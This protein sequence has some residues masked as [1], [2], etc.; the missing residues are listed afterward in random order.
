MVTISDV[1]NANSVR[2]VWPDE[3]EAVFGPGYRFKRAWI[4]LTKD[5]VTRGIEKRLPFLTTQR[6]QLT[7]PRI[8]SAGDPYVP[9]LGGFTVGN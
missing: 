6:K 3:F 1:N 2:V 8:I 7:E 5:P 9:R 4:E